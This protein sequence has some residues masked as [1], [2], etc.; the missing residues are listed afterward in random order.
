MNLLVV[1]RNGFQE[2]FKAEV[3]STRRSEAEMNKEDRLSR[4]RGQ[5]DQGKA[6]RSKWRVWEW[7]TGVKV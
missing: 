3:C 2:T 4:Q 5:H 7:E 6:Q 1:F